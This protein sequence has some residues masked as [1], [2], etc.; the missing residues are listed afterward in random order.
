[1]YCIADIFFASGEYFTTVEE[2]YGDDESETVSDPDGSRGRSDGSPD[3]SPA[4]RDSQSRAC[5]TA[6]AS[7]SA[8]AV[9]A[10]VAEKV[11]H[12]KSIV[13]CVEF[14]VCGTDQRIVDPLLSNSI[15][16][17]T[18]S[19]EC[20]CRQPMS[21]ALYEYEYVV[22]RRTRT[23]TRTSTC[24]EFV[25][26]VNVAVAFCLLVQPR[27]RISRSLHSPHSTF[28]FMEAINCFWSL[29]QGSVRVCSSHAMHSALIT[30]YY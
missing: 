17:N 13:L 27:R 26:L 15:L 20:T 21:G 25:I 10:E 2:F 28:R 7:S 8:A 14:L 6:S 12:S 23:R 22:R 30:V 4:R 11:D 19:N 24:V 3:G 16:I 9:D 5:A 29:A 1:M 18:G